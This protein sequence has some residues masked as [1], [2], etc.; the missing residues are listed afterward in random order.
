MSFP[1]NLPPGM[2][3]SSILSSMGIDPTQLGSLQKMAGNALAQAPGVSTW[4][5]EMPKD[6]LA[7]EIVVFVIVFIIALM[8]IKIWR[9]I[10]LYV[11]DESYRN[12]V[13]LLVSAPLF[14]VIFCMLGN[15]FVRAA[16]LLYAISLTYVVLCLY[17][18]VEL[19]YGVFGGTAEFAK[20]LKLHERKINFGIPPVCCL[21]CLPSAAPTEKNL[22]RMKL[23]VLQTP[24]VRIAIQIALMIMLIEGVS[25]SSAGPLVL[26]IIGVISTITGI[27]TTHLLFRMTQ[28]FL[29]DFG[30]TVLFRSV[31]LCQALLTIMK[32]IFDIL[33]RKKAFNPYGHLQSP[34]VAAFWFNVGMSF[35]CL[36]LCLLQFFFTRPGKCALFDSKFIKKTIAQRYAS[37]MADGEQQ[38][39]QNNR[40]QSSAM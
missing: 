21:T 18:L 1:G 24:I 27:Y 30:M 22:N 14:I 4:W 7:F 32:F 13:T 35:A 11:D 36:L 39:A 34:G 12:D 6:A 29:S 23:L 40:I 8:T 2:N 38:A 28:E 31:D 10:V 19:L 15:V 25:P 16:G 17:R 9:D 26:N 3:L 5:K 20:W 37:K 33:G